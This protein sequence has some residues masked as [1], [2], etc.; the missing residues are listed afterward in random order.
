[1]QIQK[2]LGGLS[3][4]LD[5]QF[6]LALSA[7]LHMGSLG[8]RA[9]RGGG[10]FRWEPLDQDSIPYPSDFD[11]Y[12]SQCNDLIRGS[13]LQ[14]TILKELYT[15]P[16]QARKDITDTLGGRDDSQSQSDLGQLRNP[17]GCIGSSGMRKTSPL[18]LLVVACQG[19]HR[20]LALWDGRYDIT[21][22]QA[23]DL[24]GAIKLLVKAN[25]PIGRQLA[26]S[27]FANL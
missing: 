10:C 19:K 27:S 5:W 25:K 1:M 16:E 8:L 15:D 22:N 3:Q 6:G 11:K 21:G 2:R 26:S 4:D 18:R 9:T 14:V 24:A 23:G 20:I 7:W 12:Q 17:L 13:K